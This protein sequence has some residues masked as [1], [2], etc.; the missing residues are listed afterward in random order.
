MGKLDRATF[1]HGGAA[2]RLKTLGKNSIHCVITSPPYFGLRDYHADGQIGLEESLSEYIE[3][4]AGVFDEVRRVLHPSGTFWLNIGDSYAGSGGPGGD[5]RDGKGGDTYKRQ[6]NRNVQ[7]LKKKDLCMV[8]SRVAITLQERG[9]W[10]RSEI[11]WAK[12]IS[13]NDKYSGSCM[14][15]SAT[16]R[17][18]NGHEKL[19]LFAKD[20]DYFYD[21]AAVAEPIEDMS[22]VG[23]VRGDTGHSRRGVDEANRIGEGSGEMKPTK[24]LR[25]VW[26]FNPASFKGAHFA[27][28]DEDTEILTKNGWKSHKSISENNEIATFHTNSETIHYHKPYSI[29]KY[30]YNGKMYRI[31]NKWIDQ[32]VTPNHRVL[33]KYRRSEYKNKD[34]EWGYQRADSITPHSG[35][36]IPNSG[37]Y[38]GELDISKEKAELLGWIITEGSNNNGSVKIWQSQSANPKKVSRIRNLL[39]E[40]SQNFNE[41]TRSREREYGKSVECNFAINKTMNDN[42]WIWKW[43]NDDLTPKWKLLHVNKKS[44]RGL[45]EGLVE[46]DGHKHEDGKHTFVQYDK[47]TN[48]WFRVLCAHIGKRTTFWNGDQRMQ[49][50]ITHQN[51]SNIHSNSFKDT[52]YTQD[53]NG[54]VWCPQVPNTNF[55][56]RRNGKIYITGNTYPLGLVEPCVKAGTSAKGVCSECGNP[57]ERVTEENVDFKSGSGK[58][59]NEPE[60]KYENAQ[61]SN[62]GDYDIRMGPTKSKETVGWEPTCD[63]DAEVEPATV[64]DPFSGAA[65]T[66]IAALKHG[67]KYIGIDV[68][69]D[70]IEMAKERIRE[71][72]Q[73]PTNHSF[74]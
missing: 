10:L 26:T 68:N 55:I 14:P 23:E 54:I 28:V 6:Y 72:K 33:L 44:L 9:W 24:K 60:G 39:Q 56:A 4:L 30:D 15:E 1:L 19:Y 35:V 2:E 22:R 51:F 46:G 27:C 70:Y 11:I 48:E 65:T 29:H 67:R 32:L 25:D 63:C 58:A 12:S 69:E 40:T 21:E 41:L 34:E 17:P 62:S 37:E 73:V 36:I 52:V 38:N 3:N 64:L 66:G 50:N 71:H 49:T 47:Y 45:Y 18:T 5:F 8:P 7:G 16:D 59:G 57:Y 61:E 43:L 31:E 74:W 20:T 42:S 53:Y 13:F